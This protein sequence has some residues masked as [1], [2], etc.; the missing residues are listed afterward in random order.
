MI[1][2]YKSKTLLHIWT[3][4]KPETLTQNQHC[5]SHIHH[6]CFVR[7][8]FCSTPWRTP[9]S[10]IK[11]LHCWFPV[12][13]SLWAPQSGLVCPETDPASHKNAELKRHRREE[14]SAIGIKMIHSMNSVQFHPIQGAWGCHLEMLWNWTLNI[15][16]WTARPQTWQTLILTYRLL[17]FID[18]SNPTFGGSVSLC[19]R[20]N[21][22]WDASSQHSCQAMPR[23]FTAKN[24]TSVFS[25]QACKNHMVFFVPRDGSY[26]DSRSAC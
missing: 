23:M 11:S 8:H 7:L 25:W 4:Q 3:T 19:L 22:I 6:V 24:A 21:C 1:Q 20:R 13:I 16:L 5:T 18:I 14:N 26:T 2:I 17:S 15:C 10:R 9:F 12:F